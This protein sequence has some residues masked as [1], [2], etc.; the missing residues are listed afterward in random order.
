MAA[1]S[2]I[3]APNGRV[4]PG[5]YGL[6]RQQTGPYEKLDEEFTLTALWPRCQGDCSRIAGP[7]LGCT[8]GLAGKS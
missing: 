1:S 8:T 4:S 7:P 2:N 5:R 3:L 6:S